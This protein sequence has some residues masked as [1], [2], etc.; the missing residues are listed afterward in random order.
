M[1][2]AI[3]VY[4][5]LS[6]LLS[7]LSHLLFIIY[8]RYHEHGALSVYNSLNVTIR[9]CKFVNNTSDSYYFE[10][11]KQYQ[12]SSGGL[13]IGYSMNDS[14][15]L[16]NIT[17]S[18]T[19]FINNNASPL[20]EFKLTSSDVLQNGTFTGR[21]GGLSVVVSSN[22]SQLNCIIRNCNFSSNFASNFGGAVYIFVTNVFNNQNY[23]FDKVT[24][25]NNSAPVAG[26]L[27]F[28]DIRVGVN[29]SCIHTT[30][31]NCTFTNNMA[32]ESG[33]AVSMYFM[34]GETNHSVEYENCE[35]CNNTAMNG[36]GGG[37]DVESYNFFR[38]RDVLH[39]VVFSN[40]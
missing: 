2:T 21:G 22:F 15:V 6:F 24:F 18:D 34:V 5:F 32:A 25:N 17:I 28:F 14:S 1:I 39:P 19:D 20:A 4:Y 7:L 3:F 9:N 8:I 27:C 38:A 10:Q 30:A 33:G 29:D 36:H 37:I 11:Q 35:F 13:S 26:A 12:G 31:V 23:S 40:W 16:L